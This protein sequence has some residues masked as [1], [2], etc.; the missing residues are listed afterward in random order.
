[1]AITITG[2]RGLSLLSRG[3]VT[4]RSAISVNGGSLGAASPAGGYAGAADATDGPPQVSG[5]GSLD[6]HHGEVD[7]GDL[8]QGDGS[9]GFGSSRASSRRRRVGARAIGTVREPWLGSRP[10]SC[11]LE[12]LLEDTLRLPLEDHGVQ[13]DDGHHPERR[14]SQDQERALGEARSSAARATPTPSPAMPA[15]A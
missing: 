8:E 15:K 11:Q 9:P 13:G 14:E 1:M 12:L 6:H 5:I 4:L 2:N 10:C 3:E 7:R